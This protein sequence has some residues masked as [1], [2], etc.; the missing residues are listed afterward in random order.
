MKKILT[1]KYLLLLSRVALGFIFLYA[2]TEK[3]ADAEGF[4]RAINN[5]KLIPFFTINI[6][7]LVLPWIEVVCGLL[8]ILGIK[9]KE[10]ALILTLLLS[11]FVAVITVSLLRGL[12]IDCGCFGTASGTKIGAQKLLENALLILL[13]LQIIYFGGGGISLLIEY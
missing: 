12:N 2:G 11:L 3:I 5:Y 6:L 10:N 4:A 1:N 8:L 7:A 13:G 9:S